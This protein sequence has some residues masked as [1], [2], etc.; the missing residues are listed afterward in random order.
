MNRRCCM[1]SLLLALSVNFGSSSSCSSARAA[2]PSRCTTFGGQACLALF[3][4]AS[5]AT[6]AAVEIARFAEEEAARR[7]ALE[8]Q[9]ERKQRAI[10]SAALPAWVTFGFVQPRSVAG[11]GLPWVG[12]LSNDPARSADLSFA[13]AAHSWLSVTTLGVQGGA[14]VREDAVA[15]SVVSA[16]RAWTRNLSHLAADTRHST[17]S[18][19]VVTLNS[20]NDG[21]AAAPRS[22]VTA[23]Q[24]RHWFEDYTFGYEYTPHDLL[25]GLEHVRPAR[26]PAAIAP[27]A[28]DSNASIDERAEAGVSEAFEEIL[29]GPSRYVFLRAATRSRDLASSGNVP[30]IACREAAGLAAEQTRREARA[31]AQAWLDALA[32]SI[33][34]CGVALIGIS[35]HLSEI[36]HSDPAVAGVSQQHTE[37]ADDRNDAADSRSHGTPWMG[38]DHWDIEAG[39]S[40]NAYL[41]L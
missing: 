28:D 26:R 2:E 30:S 38:C 32:G 31:K 40:T 12:P 13:Y 10:D 20:Q 11:D 23:E 1:L 7:A 17:G 19:E 3:H 34:K 6:T 8:A 5:N 39:V 14:S 16:K 27:L 36:A 24:V 4:F 21:L 18:D 22:K 9:H 37:E 15:V 29:A 35:Q 33:H 25:A 41:G